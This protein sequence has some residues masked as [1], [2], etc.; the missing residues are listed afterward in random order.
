MSTARER[1]LPFISAYNDAAVVAGGGTIALEVMEDLP[2]T[3]TMVV[4]AGGGGLISGIGVAAHGLDPAIAV[5]GAQ[6]TASPALHAA[7]EAGA[8]VRVDVLPSLAD[9]LSGNVEDGSIT[10][11]LLKEH[12]RQV[13]LVTESDIVDAMRWLLEH[14][15]VLV[16][17]SAAVGVAALLRGLLPTEGPL[18]LV[19]TGRNVAAEVLRQYVLA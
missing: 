13:V 14:E 16:E 11:D 7:L 12:V 17:G 4:P 18:V 2:A 10:F 6:S 1:G 8:R 19:L 3:R 15:H 9:G 5:Y